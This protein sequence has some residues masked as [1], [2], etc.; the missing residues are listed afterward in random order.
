MITGTLHHFFKHTHRLSHMEDCKEL[1]LQLKAYFDLSKT[2]ITG[3]WMGLLKIQ[4]L[5]AVQI[6]NDFLYSLMPLS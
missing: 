6:E 2:S 5:P 1:A 4:T 3:E